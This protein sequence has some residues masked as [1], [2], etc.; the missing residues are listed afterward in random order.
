MTDDEIE[1]TLHDA[2][3][4]Q[5]RASVGDHASP[6][7]PRFAAAPRRNRRR[8]R[9]FAPLAAAAAVIAVVASVAALDDSPSKHGGVVAG[10]R[11]SAAASS[12]AAPSAAPTTLPS[13]S[14]RVADGARLGTASASNAPLRMVHIKLY[15]ADG[16][17]Y[18]VGMP[19]VAYFSGEITQAKSLTKAT[20][21]SI[22]GR[23]AQG[24]WYFERSA[25]L[26]GY[27]I[28]AHLRL[29]SYWPEHAK[30]HVALATKGISAGPGLAFDDALTLDFKTGPR[31]VAVVDD[32]RHRMT[33]T[34]DNRTIGTFPV[35]LGSKQTPTTRGTKVVM[36]KGRSI[37]MTGPGYHECG[38]KDTQRLTYSGEYLHAAPWNVANIKN[39][40]D[41]SN[42]CTNLLPA[43]AALVYK[44]LEVGDLVMYPNASGPQMQLGSGFGDWNVPW[45][46]WQQGG[47]VPT[48]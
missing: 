40:V 44:S 20:S 30:I 10:G 15:N 12:T 16:A 21:I 39:G 45:A 48:S 33:V 41:S 46:T 8:A 28:E 32:V 26:S 23:P 1:R 22:D 34:S 38:I 29:Q 25:A 42:G 3:E 6:P 37:C 31:T 4:A 7:P 19:V 14:V 11:S 24:A 43:D 9:V 18:G 36:E 17:T 13:A 47:L 5:A 35:S 27:P 2:F